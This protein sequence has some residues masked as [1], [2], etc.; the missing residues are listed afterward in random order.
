MSNSHTLRGRNFAFLIYQ[1]QFEK[2]KL[3]LDNHHFCGFISPLHT[4][5]NKP[6]YH[7]LVMFDNPRSKDLFQNLVASELG[8][9]HFE[10]V[11]NLPGY[12]RYLCHLDSSNKV[13]YSP[14][15]VLS[16]GGADYD[17]FSSSS[18]NV[19][20]DLL[21][22]IDSSGFIYYDSFVISLLNSSPSLFACL[23]SPKYSR[24]IKSVI[25]SHNFKL[26]KSGLL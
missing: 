19:L 4:D 16:F 11:S 20:S 23:S 9:V 6:H 7:V 17:K 14:D 13:K 8:V 26:S 15:D 24:I 21:D 18:R 12:A 10:D 25:D 1:D 2:C 5:E 3:F 22:I